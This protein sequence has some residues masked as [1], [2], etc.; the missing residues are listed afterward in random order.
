MLQK[1]FLV[2]ADEATLDSALPVSM[3]DE[4]IA[5]I[6]GKGR[7]NSVVF[8]PYSEVRAEGPPQARRKTG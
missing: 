5:A 8:S 2:I 1:P 3:A 4:R 7:S 6:G